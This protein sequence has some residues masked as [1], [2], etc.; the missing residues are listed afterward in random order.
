MKASLIVANNV[1]GIGGLTKSLIL[2]SLISSNASLNPIF[3][4]IVR[5]VRSRLACI[6][7][8]SICQ[9]LCGFAGA[10]ESVKVGGGKVDDIEIFERVV[11]GRGLRSDWATTK[12]NL[13]RGDVLAIHLIVGTYDVGPEDLEAEAVNVAQKI[14]ATT[15]VVTS[16]HINGQVT[17]EHADDV[18]ASCD[19]FLKSNANLSSRNAILI[20][21]DANAQRCAEMA[22][23]SPHLLSKPKSD[24]DLGDEHR[25]GCASRLSMNKDGDGIVTVIA[26]SPKESKADAYL[27]RYCLFDRTF[28]FLGFR[29]RLVYSTGAT[30]GVLDSLRTV[31]HFAVIP[32]TTDLIMMATAYQYLGD[33]NN[34]LD[35]RETIKRR[36][37]PLK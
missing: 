9:F 16:R 10:E 7:V 35:V 12:L 36:L 22:E 15:G 23:K 17:S 29:G 14:V 33:G 34:Y 21:L 31:P 4:L 13:L 26:A 1:E 5:T 24:P 30:E 20:V 37:P 3:S 19:A 18:A 25:L 11:L 27:L 8:L 6:M 28:S 32:G 2:R